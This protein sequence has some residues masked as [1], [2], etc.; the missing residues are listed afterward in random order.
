M[1]LHAIVSP[2]IGVVN[3]N[4]MAT[5]MMSTGYTIDANSKQVPAYT[6]FDRVPAQVQALSFG[7]IQKLAGLNL[8]GVRRAIYLTGNWDGLV[9]GERR[10]GDLIVIG[11][12]T[13]LVA[14]ALESWPDWTKVAATL[15]VA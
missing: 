1:N 4:V 14:I 10:G 15:Q 7:D 3:P 5:V 13:W 9:R 6:Q 12:Q 11:D 8:Q 2:V